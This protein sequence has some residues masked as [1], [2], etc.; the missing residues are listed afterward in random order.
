MSSLASRHEAQ[1]GQIIAEA[2][3][4]QTPFTA[5]GRERPQRKGVQIENSYDG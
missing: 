4:L 3:R 1:A 5:M 2:N